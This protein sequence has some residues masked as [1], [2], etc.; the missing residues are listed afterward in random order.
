[1]TRK[2]LLAAAALALAAGPAGA[3]VTWDTDDDGSVNA[4]EFVKGYRSAEAFNR[5]DDD[6]DSA[7]TPNELGLSEP[8]AVFRAADENGDG[9]LTQREISS[10]TFMSY[11]EDAS[12][13]LEGDEVSR[14]ESDVETGET[15]LLDDIGEAGPDYS[16]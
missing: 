11:D 10:M 1:M 14:L 16:Q 2:S 8:D 5:F 6:D 15:P 3:A 4:Q 12:G 13:A 7:L 9:E